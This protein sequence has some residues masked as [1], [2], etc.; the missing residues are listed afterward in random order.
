MIGTEINDQIF[1]IVINIISIIS[2]FAA[3]YVV[4]YIKTKVDAE[5]LLE[6]E[7]KLHI[8][9]NL[10]KEAIRFAEQQGLDLGVKGQEKFTIACNW[11]SN[12]LKKEGISITAEQIEGFIKAAL[13]DVKDKFGEEWVKK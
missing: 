7:N 6:I 3:Y 12:R 4:K 2:A 10:A 1:Q 8:F 9:K 11:M 5:K 13:R